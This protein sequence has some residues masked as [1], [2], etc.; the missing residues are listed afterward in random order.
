MSTG[1][2]LLFSFLVESLVVGT[3]LLWLN[4]EK[5]GPYRGLVWFT[6]SLGILLLAD[7]GVLVSYW[8]TFPRDNGLFL[9]FTA[10]VEVVL[11]A[12]LALTRRRAHQHCRPWH[13][14]LWLGA[15][16]TIWSIAGAAA[17]VGVL[18][19]SHPYSVSGLSTMVGRILEAGVVLS[20]CLYAV[21]LPYMLLMFRSP[22]F[23]QRFHVWLGVAAE[24]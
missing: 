13:F 10:I 5:V 12:A 6:G 19:L 22:F 2:E 7:M 3:A 23:R 21:N 1:T 11:L 9:T 20:L 8:G 14:M 4:A 16:C 17:F 18:A 15:W 24:S